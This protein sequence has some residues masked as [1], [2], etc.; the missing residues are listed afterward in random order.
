MNKKEIM[1]LR[2]LFKPE[3][4]AIDFVVNAYVKHTEDSIQIL[5]IEKNRLLTM[6]DTAMLKHLDLSK[7]TLGGSLEKNLLNIDIPTSE[8]GEDGCQDRL[9]KVLSSN[10]QDD[11]MLR[12]FIEHI[13]MHCEIIEPFMIQLVHGCYDV[14]SKKTDDSE[15]VYT[16]MIC[17]ICPM[18]P[19][20]AGICYDDAENKFKPIKQKMIADK[21]VTGFLYPA[22]NERATDLYQTLFYVKKPNDVPVDFIE[23]IAGGKQPV[24]ANMQQ[25]LF[26]D[27]IKESAGDVDFETMKNIHEEIRVCIDK[28]HFAETDTHIGKSDI[29]AIISHTCPNVEET[30]I[31]NAYDKIMAEYDDSSLALENITDTT[32]FD[33]SIPDITIKAKPDKIDK[34]EQKII[35]GKKCFIIPVYGNIEINGIPVA[36]K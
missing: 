10:F 25:S 35:D 8:C 36:D 19:E 30:V 5:S 28:A 1:E 11:A 33:V 17:S 27:I 22:F 24:P 31:S 9:Y 34:I 12:D 20:K 32:K 2:K 7:K 3:T 14:I 4:T 18:I 16:Y 21:P 13:A 29:Q 26:Q 15:T 23:A 6:D